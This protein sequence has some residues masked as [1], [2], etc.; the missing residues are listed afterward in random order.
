[1]S[2]NAK[3]KEVERKITEAVDALAGD[4]SIRSEDWGIVV[5]GNSYEPAGDG[6]CCPMAAVLLHYQDELDWGENFDNLELDRGED[7][8]NWDFDA[9]AGQILGIDK[10]QV[11]AF[12][13]AFDSGKAG[14]SRYA[15]LGRKL[16]NKYLR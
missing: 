10:G 13:Y 1:M 2:N 9:A 4:M 14:G 8:D 7:F 6:A 5:R 15:R 16:R 12:I 3:I 11:D